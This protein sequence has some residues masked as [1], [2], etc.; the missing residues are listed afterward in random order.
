MTKKLV[1]RLINLSTATADEMLEWLSPWMIGLWR[2]RVLERDEETGAEKVPRFWAVTLCH[3][4][5]YWDTQGNVTKEDALRNAITIVCDLERRYGP[6][7]LAE[8]E[9]SPGKLTPAKMKRLLKLQ[10]PSLPAG[11]RRG[12]KGSRSGRT[13]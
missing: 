12:G 9:N 8:C 3:H 7:P 1:D 13:A 11:K 2:F 6:C 10:Q 5:F 4:G